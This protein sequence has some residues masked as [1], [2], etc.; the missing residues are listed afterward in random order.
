M[1]GTVVFGEP[2]RAVLAVLLTE[3]CTADPDLS[4]GAACGSGGSWGL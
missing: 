3:L 4:W 1:S 2:V